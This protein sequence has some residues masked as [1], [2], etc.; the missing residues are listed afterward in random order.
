MLAEAPDCLLGDT[1]EFDP[2]VEEGSGVRALKDLPKE[3]QFIR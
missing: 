1:F 2:F 3:T